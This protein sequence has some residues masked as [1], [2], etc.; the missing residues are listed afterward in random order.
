[1]GQLVAARPQRR[2]RL[3][4]H[5]AGARHVAVQHDQSARRVGQL[6]ALRLRVGVAG[7][8]DAAK[9]GP[10]RVVEVL[11]EVMRPPQVEEPARA[12]W[13]QGV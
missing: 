13:G 12:G 1:V 5:G 4:E 9:D 8:G 10:L 6:A 3:D 11:A 7:G 2:A